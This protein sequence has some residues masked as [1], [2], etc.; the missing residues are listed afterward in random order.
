MTQSQMFIDSLADAIQEAVQ[1]LGGAKKVGSELWPEKSI[2]DANNQLLNCLNPDHAQKLSLE[3][4][5]FIFGLARKEGAHVIPQYIAQKYGYQI[6]PIEP[7]DERAQLQR[8]Y[9]QAVEALQSITNRLDRV[10]G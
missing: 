10:E 1:Q 8:E 4:V 3:Q 6:T 5:D 9:I 2:R 7:E